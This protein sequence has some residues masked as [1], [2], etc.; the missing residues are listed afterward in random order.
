MSRLD[1]V[2]YDERIKA[3]GVLVQQEASMS[4]SANL[5]QASALLT[6]FSLSHYFMVSYIEVRHIHC[7]IQSKRLFYEGYSWRA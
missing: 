2:Q 7:V 4:M 5:E 1:S 6:G 3:C